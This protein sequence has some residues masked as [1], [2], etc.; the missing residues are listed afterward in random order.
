MKH[1]RKSIATILALVYGIVAY[2]Q[3]LDK[4]YVNKTVNKIIDVIDK[5]YIIPELKTEVISDISANLEQGKYHNL[6]DHKSLAKTLT[7]D[8]K[9]SSGDFHLYVVAKASDVEEKTSPVRQMRRMS[10]DPKAFENLLSYTILEGN[11]AYLKIP[12]FAPLEYIKEDLDAFLET[13]LSADAI[14]VDVR[15]CPGGSGETLA[16]LAGG[17]VAKETH[18]TTYYSKTEQQSLYTPKT[19]FG[20]INDKKEVFVLTNGNTGSAAEGFA[21]YL[22]QIGRV[23]VV[24]APSAGGGRSNEFFPIDDVLDLSVS[25]RTSVTPNGKQFQGVGVQP[26]VFTPENNAL[27]QAQILAL[28]SLQE[29]SPEQKPLYK[30]LLKEIGKDRMK[31]QRGDKQNITKTVLGYL[32]NFFENNTEEMLKYL[33]PQLAKRG[34]SKKRGESALFFQD[35][36]MDELKAMLERKPAFPMEKQQNKVEIQD[37]FFNSASVKVTTGYPGRMEWI[38]YIHLFKLNGEWKIA[39]ILWD[40][41]PRKNQKTK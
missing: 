12:L 31:Y 9:E 6:P 40:Y 10:P 16:Y 22:Q 30:N 1:T 2:T 41:F 25:T 26:A 14:I 28:Q 27:K 4:S 3:D 20:P 19:K 34:I 5:N 15:D 39:N 21:F 7:R 18:L 17:I 24:G 35:M 11:I 13:T 37:V 23:T 8:L 32:E 38:E 36:E 29:K 33:H